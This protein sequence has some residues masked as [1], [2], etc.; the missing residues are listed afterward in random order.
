MVPP[1][2]SKHQVASPMSV[3]IAYSELPLPE[4]L[5]PFVRRVLVASLDEAKTVTI[6]ARPTGYCY[7]GWVAQGQAIARA[8]E[9]EFRIATDHYHL[10]GNLTTFDAEY[11][12]FG[13]AKHLLAE[14]TAVGAHRLMKR[15]L[16]DLV[17]VIEFAPFESGT[18]TDQER[19][20]DL[21]TSLVADCGP[22]EPLVERAARQ[23]EASHGLLSIA[24]LAQ[25]LG[26][27]ERQLHRQFSKVTGLSP[28][29]FATVQK[30]LFA[31]GRLSADPTP[32]LADV[33][34]EAGFT[35]QAHFTKYFSRYIGATPAKLELDD[36]G[37]L[38]TIVLG[39][40]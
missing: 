36:D 37:V 9:R 25:E 20:I 23:I 11:S 19:F 27:S 18:G 8:N 34:A 5:A 40:K 12:L 33:A 13:P 24:G 1:S 35:D 14:C 6:P 28:K 38:R 30:V 3:P 21:L 7:V 2:V 15:D 22:D 16:R 17:N 29:A 31:L 4:F 39:A 10:S 32:S 26:V